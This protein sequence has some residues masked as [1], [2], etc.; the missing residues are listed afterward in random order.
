MRKWFCFELKT[1]NFYSLFLSVFFCFLFCDYLMLQI[2]PNHE[3]EAWYSFSSCKLSPLLF[4]L[5]VIRVLL[6]LVCSWENER[7][8][9]N[10]LIDLLIVLFM[11]ISLLAARNSFFSSLRFS[12]IWGLFGLL[13]SWEKEGKVRSFLDDRLIG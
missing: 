13:I 9:W 6:C 12:V 2:W 11:L 7:K 3:E 5:I 1:N 10:F 4:A 8:V